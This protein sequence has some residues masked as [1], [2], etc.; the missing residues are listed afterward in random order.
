MCANSTFEVKRQVKLLET[1]VEKTETLLKRFT[2]AEITQLDK[3]L[4]TVL[5]E[6]DSDVR[7]QAA[8]DLEGLRQFRFE[9]NKTL[10][11]SLNSDGIG[12]I[13]TYVTNTCAHQSTTDGK[14]VREASVGLSTT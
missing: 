2:N 13:R 7:K 11:D 8:A 9:E 3:S 10:L 4:N 5:P 1:T 6:E 14:G 12:S